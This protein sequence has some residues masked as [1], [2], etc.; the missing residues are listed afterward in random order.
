MEPDQVK[1]ASGLHRTR[2]LDM[3]GKHDAD[4]T[5]QGGFMDFIERV[6]HISPDGGTGTFELLLLLIPLAIV[7]VLRRRPA[8]RSRPTRHG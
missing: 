4:C 7:I 1:S 5:P 3:D 8:A 2:Q 6:W